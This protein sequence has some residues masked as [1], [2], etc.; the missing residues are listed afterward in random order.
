MILMRG[1]VALLLV[2]A[3][4][5]FFAGCGDAKRIFWYAD[6]VTFSPDGQTLAAP[7]HSGM[8]KL[9]D[10]SSWRET[11]VIKTDYR[12]FKSIAFSPDAKTL[13]VLDSYGPQLWDVDSRTHVGSLLPD[14]G[15]SCMHL[16]KDWELL[17]AGCSDRTALVWDVHG[18]AQPLAIKGHPKTVNSVALSPDGRMLATGSSD[19]TS[20]IWDVAT[21]EVLHT[22]RGHQGTVWSVAFSPDGRTLATGGWN[23]SVKLW[24][25]ATGEEA[26]KLIG[27][28]ESVRS[29]VFTG[30]G[31]TLV[32]GSDDATVTLWN[33]ESQERRSRLQAQGAVKTV[34]LSP[35]GRL[36]AAAFGQG[37]T[38]FEVATGEEVAVLK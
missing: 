5:P 7:T 34:T 20:I 29:V 32:G 9:W 30:D 16:S 37:V 4:A 15:I 23:G 27:P 28:W 3:F 6:C 22:L 38:V 18:D 26:A 31:R 11:A 19:A 8:V 10:C 14:I 1:P 25:T 13:A 24:N 12:E 2:T 21:G 33:V 36:V 17:G 35:D